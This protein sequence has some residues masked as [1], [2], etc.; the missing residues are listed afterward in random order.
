MTSFVNPL[1]NPS[2]S[3]VNV[4]HT[5]L[6]TPRLEFEWMRSPFQKASDILPLRTIPQFRRDFQTF[7]LDVQTC[8]SWRAEKY[9]V[10]ASRC[11]CTFQ[12][13]SG[14]LRNPN[15]GN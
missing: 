5:Q 13:R 7:V 11:R 1:R 12:T 14:Q 10:L 6:T 15:V 3:V 2:P 8:D 9:R 4:N